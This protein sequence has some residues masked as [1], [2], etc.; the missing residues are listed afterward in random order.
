[1]PNQFQR[2]DRNVDVVEE[3]QVDVREV[4]KRRCVVA[5]ESDAGLREVGAPEYAHRP[6]APA[7]VAGSLAIEKALHV[8]Q[9]GYKLLVVAFAEIL[10]VGGE[11]VG[12]LVPLARRALLQQF[13]VALDL[14][15]A[16]M[17]DQ[18]NRP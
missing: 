1:M 10:R 13:P 4:E 16:R 8:R 5:G 17:R 3:M 6:R 7:F 14:L 11:L 12:N 2:E 18:L 15:P 9:E